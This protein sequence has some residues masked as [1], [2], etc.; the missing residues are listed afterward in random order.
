[1]LRDMGAVFSFKTNVPVAMMMPDSI[2]HIYRNIPN[3]DLSSGGSSGG[4]CALGALLGRIYCG[5][6]S[7]IGGSAKNSCGFAE[8]IHPETFFPAGFQHLEAALDFQA[9]N[10]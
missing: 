10:L 2:N 4:E 3:R 1:M 8:P 7:D 6:G 9:W 5:I